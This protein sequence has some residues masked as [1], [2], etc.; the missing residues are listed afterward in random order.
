MDKIPLNFDL[1]SNP[2]N[3]IR[4]TL[5]VVIA[6]VAFDLIAAPLLKKEA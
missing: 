1:M 5:M 4:V 3:W 2:T 6:G